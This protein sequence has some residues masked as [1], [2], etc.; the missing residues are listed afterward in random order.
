MQ[1]KVE[2]GNINSIQ[3]SPT[4]QATRSNYTK[5]HG[6]NSPDYLDY[7]LQKKGVV[8][9]DQLQ[10]E[11][12]GR[13]LKKR[14]RNMVIEINEEIEIKENFIW[15]T[16]H[17]LKNLSKIDNLLNMDSRTVL[18][19]LNF[20]NDDIDDFKYVLRSKKSLFLKKMVEIKEFDK[21]ISQV[22]R[23]IDEIKTN[24][25]FETKK[26]SLDKMKNWNIKDDGIF[27]RNNNFFS[28]EY[29]L[30]HAKGREVS[31]WSQPL[32]C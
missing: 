12:A 24:L 16:M 26:L 6:G 25:E 19:C 14:N 5:A 30:I 27:N 4:L 29:F 21:S 9:V 2:P 28:L 1:A 32:F 15:L 3:L 22:L 17:D 7:F 10:P 11:Q 20:F 13:F 18:A 31:N 23:W 8:I